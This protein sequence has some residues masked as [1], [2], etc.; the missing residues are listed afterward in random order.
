MQMCKVCRPYHC[1]TFYWFHFQLLMK[2]T[3][4]DYSN[5]DVFETGDGDDEIELYGS[6]NA[7]YTNNGNDNII[8]GSHYISY[9]ERLNKKI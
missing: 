1:F 8:L 2:K 6:K 7:V 9:T 3:I 4:I 5:V